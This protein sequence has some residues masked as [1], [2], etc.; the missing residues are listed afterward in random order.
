MKK[1]L[2]L[3]ISFLLLAGVS[4]AVQTKVIVRAKAKDAKF[5]GSM[6]GGAL[7]VIRDSDT[8]EALAKGFTSGG[9]GD[10]RKIMMEPLKRGASITDQSAA[11]FEAVLDIDE[12][13]LVTIEVSAPY[14]Q[15]QSLEKN[16]TQ[17]WLI[18]G[19][20]ITGDGI[21]IDVYGFSVKALLP[22]THEMLKLAGGRITVPVRANVVMMCGCPVTAGG[23]WD[24][25][26]Y[27]VKA[28][29]K[30]NGKT[31]ETIPLSYAGK[32]NT[33]EG[34]VE[35]TK[36]GAYEITIYAFDA[37]TGNSGVDRTTFMVRK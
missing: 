13:K 36:E 27:E 30:H 34:N 20:D 17:V 6:M 18:P 24:A 9:T 15:R 7:V 1:L 12:P 2:L 14:A 23:L 11:K 26:K 8:G 32:P 4:E 21:I 22:Q 16:S 25:D 37:A 29:I 10:T 3:L 33:F 19:K 5:I 35:V 31:A 28:L